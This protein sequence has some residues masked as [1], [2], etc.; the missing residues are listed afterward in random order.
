MTA[1]QNPRGADG[2]TAGEPLDIMLPHYGDTGLMQAAVRSVLEQSD[3]NWRLTV[4]DDGKEPGVPEWFASLGDSRVRYLRNE[5]NLGITRNF[6]KCVDLVES[7][8]FSMLGSDDLL[9]PDYVATM[10]AAVAAFPHAT[11]YQPGVEVIDEHGKPSTTLGD[12][13]KKRLYAPKTTGRRLVL[14][15]ESLAANLLGGNWLYFPSIVWRA[16]A[17]K[18]ISFREDLS[19]IQDLALIIELIRRG[20][21]LVVDPTTVFRYRRHSGSLSSAEAVSGA[22]FGEAV[23]FFHE[24]AD[25][26]DAHGWPKAARAARRHLSMRLHALTMVPGAVRHGQSKTIR[27]LLGYA[28]STSQR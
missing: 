28:L 17:V 19:V 9:L 12:E 7:R 5:Q 6:R 22:R 4:V 13:V 23:R 14:S 2:T 16:D 11:I 18:E 1:V 10:R 8:H 15:G 20:G 25:D 26:L 27:T 21:K 24:V 3:P